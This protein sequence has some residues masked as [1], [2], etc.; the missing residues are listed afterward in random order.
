L[1]TITRSKLGAIVG[2]VLV[3]GLALTGCSTPAP[4]GD[5]TSGADA[6]TIGIVSYDTT[7]V[8]AKAETDGATAAIEAEGWTALSQDPKG[9][10]A[11]ANSICTQYVTRQVDVIVISVFSSD[12]MAQCMSAAS[13]A[14]IPVFYLASSLET[15][16]AGAIG[17][18]VPGPINEAMISA[19]KDLPNLRILAMTLQPGAP[20]R[21]READ[22]DDQLEAAGLSDKIDKHEVVVPGQVTDAQAATTAWLSAHPE[23]AGEDLVIWSCFADPA[24]GAYAALQ[25]AG[26]DVPIYTW[27]LTKPAVDPIK[28]GAFAAV[29]AIDAAGEGVQL[30]GLIKDFLAGGEPQSLDAASTVLTKDNIDQYLADNP[31]AAN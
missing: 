10:P 23:S 21:A 6:L 20:C 19:V 14:S 16:M 31:N 2:T 17:T 26:R 9:D 4:S 11:Q 22:L 25:Q 7:T 30:V 12:Q 1:S 8:S 29:L 3:A 15:G 13:G 5:S 28:S 24:V 27:D 18:S